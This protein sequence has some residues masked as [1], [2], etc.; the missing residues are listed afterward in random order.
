[1]HTYNIYEHRNSQRNAVLNTTNVDTV[2]HESNTGVRHPYDGMSPYYLY[3]RPYQENN[4]AYKTQG[5]EREHM[6]EVHVIYNCAFMCVCVC[7]IF[8]SFILRCSIFVHTG[9]E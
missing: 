2:N 3:Y 8:D 9:M 1:M 6:S 4:T 5:V 7:F